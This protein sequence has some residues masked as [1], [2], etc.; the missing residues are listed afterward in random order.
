MLGL[1]VLLPQHQSPSSPHDSLGVLHPTAGSLPLHKVLWRS[2]PSLVQAWLNHSPSE[3]GFV[4]GDVNQ[5]DLPGILSPAMRVLSALQKP[6]KV[7]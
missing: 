6:R 7:L 1:W 3:Y 5:E 2:L 4:G